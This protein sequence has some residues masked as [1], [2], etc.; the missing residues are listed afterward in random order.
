MLR[1]SWQCFPPSTHQQQAYLLSSLP[2]LQ[3][4]TARTWSY[5]LKIEWV[6]TWKWLINMKRF[7]GCEKTALSKTAVKQGLRLESWGFPQA[8]STRMLCYFSLCW[9]DSSRQTDRTIGLW[10][11]MQSET[12]TG[13]AL[14]PLAGKQPC[15]GP[16]RRETASAQCQDQATTQCLCSGSKWKQSKPMSTWTTDLVWRKTACNYNKRGRLFLQ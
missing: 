2:D 14:W 12:P 9:D 5:F 4:N 11:Y 10:Y 8:N 13:T 7:K 15:C 16:S 3:P 6:R 1:H